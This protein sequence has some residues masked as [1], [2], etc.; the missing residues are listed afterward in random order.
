MIGKK[1]FYSFLPKMCW[2]LRRRGN[3]Y[4]CHVFATIVLYFMT[5]A[6]DSGYRL[7]IFTKYS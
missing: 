3:F 1:N 6:F 5:Y 4:M 7:Y 2:E